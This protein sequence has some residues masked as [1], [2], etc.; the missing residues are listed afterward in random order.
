[1]G[2]L[3]PAGEQEWGGYTCVFTQ[4][5]QFFGIKTPNNKRRVWSRAS[6]SFTGRWSA[7]L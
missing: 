6:S 1:M 4:T 2:V 7:R 5:H 3:T